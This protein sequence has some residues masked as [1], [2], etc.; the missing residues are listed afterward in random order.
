MRWLLVLTLTYSFA[1]AAADPAV[2]EFSDP[3]LAQRFQEITGELRCLVC[4]NQSLADS[5]AELA[6]DLRREIFA[7]M[8]AGQTDREIL[9]FMVRRYGEFVLYR[10]PVTL[11]TLALWFG[12]AVILCVGIWFLVRTVRHRRRQSLT[13]APAERERVARLLGTKD[14]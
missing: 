10:P 5:H 2:F 14:P 7:M 12:P 9:D 3:A 1:A 8:Q 11:K 4:Q 13:L 6:G